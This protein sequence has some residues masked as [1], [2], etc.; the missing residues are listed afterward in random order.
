MHRLSEDVLETANGPHDRYD[1][2]P[3]NKRNRHAPTGVRRT[4]PPAVTSKPGAEA[5]NGSGFRLKHL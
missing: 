4:V 1:K 5:I 2:Q 3:R